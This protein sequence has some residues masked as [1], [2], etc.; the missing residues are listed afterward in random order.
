MAKT[1]PKKKPPHLHAVGGTHR[2]D[3]HG[4]KPEA[5]AAPPNN[6]AIEPMS[7]LTKI[8][9]KVWDKLIKPA[10]WLTEFDVIKAHEFV[11]LAAEFFLS[12]R[13]FLSSRHAQLRA[14]QSELGLEYLIASKAKPKL[15][16]GDEFFD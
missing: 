5:A 2:K 8:E 6:P 15:N 4:E 1:G 11:A 10:T 13:G 14:L 3:R 9:A 7:K 16:P 12:K